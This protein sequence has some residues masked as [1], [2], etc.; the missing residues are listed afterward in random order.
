MPS[1]CGPSSVREGAARRRSAEGGNAAVRAERTE[2]GLGDAAHVQIV[3]DEIDQPVRRPERAQASLVLPVRVLGSSRAIPADGACMCSSVS[4]V[5]KVS[6]LPSTN[7]G[8]TPSSASQTLAT[9]T[10]SF[11]GSSRR[12][13][14]KKPCVPEELDVAG[15]QPF[16]VGGR[17]EVG[18]PGAAREPRQDVAPERWISSSC[19]SSAALVGCARRRGAERVVGRASSATACCHVGVEHGQAPRH[20]GGRGSAATTSPSGPAARLQLH[21]QTATV[22]G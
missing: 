16:A 10:L 14:I 3:R 22:C 6:T 5:P 20:S 18:R 21:L 13:L 15:L 19:C 11:C 17:G 7:R 12:F 1:L 4:G 2:H 9:A 8:E